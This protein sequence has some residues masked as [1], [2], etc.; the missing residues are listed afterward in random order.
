MNEKSLVVDEIKIVPIPINIAH[1]DT[2]RADRFLA[3]VRGAVITTEGDF[4]VCGENLKKIN[5][6]IA[7]LEAKRISITRPLDQAKKV[8]MELFNIPIAKL[9]T[10]RGLYKRIIGGYL[11]KVEE[12]QR[13]QA[14]AIRKQQQIE[15]AKLEA[16]AEKLEV[17][18]KVEQADALR[19][20]AEIKKT[21]VPVMPEAP[22][23][24]G[25]TVTERWTFEIVD[26]S[27][28][29]REYLIPDLVR[30]GKVARAEQGKRIIPGVIFKT[31]K[32]LSS[33]K[34]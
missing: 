12:E 15:A 11:A 2:T 8:V 22:K 7:M 13:K 25:I 1:D 30:L 6:C 18:G 26:E 5:G 17:K 10:A 31:E 34:I 27:L 32:G 23:V 28:I 20:Q 29:P 4:Q 24:K 16:Q 3:E 14:E 9:E 19:E 21:L 33:G